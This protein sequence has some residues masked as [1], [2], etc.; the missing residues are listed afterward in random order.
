[1][2]MIRTFGSVAEERRT[3]DVV[4]LAMRTIDGGELNL[5]FL[6][7]PLI[8]EPL[9]GQPLSLA[10]T[11]F[12]YLKDLELAD[13]DCHGENLE[14]NVLIGSDHYWKVVSGN[15]VRGKGGPTAIETR[16]GWVLSGPIDGLACNN[17]VATFIS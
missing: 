8:C 16:F 15:V 9:T 4:R 11:Q 10:V 7:V 13:V 1:M 3:C 17:T 5:E 12:P 14:V 6:T 2:M